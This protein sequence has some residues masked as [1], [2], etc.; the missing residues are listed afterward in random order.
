MA[1]TRKPSMLDVARGARV[2]IATVSRA[3]N[4]PAL[5]QAA[6]LERINET[7]RR[8][9]YVPNRRARTLA[10]GRSH[11]IGVVMPTLNSAIFSLTLKEMQRV[12]YAEGYQ[13]LVA[14]HE[15][16]VSSETAAVAQLLSHGVDG[17]ILVGATRPEATWRLIEAAQ[18]P[19]VQLWCG[20]PKHDCIS[21]DNKLAGRLIAT[22]LLEL[23]H[24]DFGVLCGHLRNND[25]QQARLEG[26]REALRARGLELGAAQIVETHLSIGSGRVSCRT[27][28]E[29]TPRATAIIGLVDVLAIGAMIEAQTQGIA[30]PDQISVGGVDNVEFAAHVAPSLTT[31]HIP[32]AEIGAHA[33]LRMKAQLDERGPVEHLTLPIDLVK[34]RSTGPAPGT[35]K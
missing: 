30:V 1:R 21:V 20:A 28:L 26:V 10:S 7:T 8:L 31:I 25:R 34:R 32:S 18:V 2:S 15:Y 19:L 27:L 9:G 11:T 13:M 17:L 29:V 16:E 23:G 12:L 35:R 6:T 4:E 24:V 14:S 5:V 33:A 3:L 22:H